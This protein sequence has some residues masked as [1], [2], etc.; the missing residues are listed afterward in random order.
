MPKFKDLKSLYTYINKSINKSLVNDVAPVVE[1]ALDEAIDSTVYNSYTPS[2]YDRR[3]ELGNPKNI[4][5]ELIQDGVLITKDIAQP[6]DSVLGYTYVPETDTIFAGW[7]NEGQVP[8]IFNGRDDYP[9]MHERDFI[10]NAINNLKESGDVDEALKRGLEK[11]GI[12]V[13]TSVKKR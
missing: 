7:I 3:F 12:A 6:N 1:K 10:G 13:K 4:T 2:D 9:W 5:S 11:Q 8:N